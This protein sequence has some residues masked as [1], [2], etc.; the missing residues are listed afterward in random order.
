MLSRRDFKYARESL[1]LLKGA[2]DDLGEG[3]AAVGEVAR[4][5]ADFIVRLRGQPETDKR[6]I[7]ASAPRRTRPLSFPRALTLSLSLSLSLTLSLSLSLSLSP[8]LWRLKK[9]S[10]AL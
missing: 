10:R 5:D 9:G 3:L 7:R 2:A 4:V 6:K 8:S 1:Q